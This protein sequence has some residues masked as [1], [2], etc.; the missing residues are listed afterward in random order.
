MKY[1]KSNGSRVCGPNSKLPW[2]T[3]KRRTR[4]ARVFYDDKLTVYMYFVIVI[5]DILSNRQK[6][7]YHSI[8]SAGPQTGYR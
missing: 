6:I 5:S 2:Q 3:V 4:P 7:F 1:T 8:D